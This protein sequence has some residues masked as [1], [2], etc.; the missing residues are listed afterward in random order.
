MAVTYREGAS[1][2]HPYALVHD[3][4]GYGK[5]LVAVDRYQTSKPVARL[6]LPQPT[7]TRLPALRSPIFRARDPNFEHLLPDARH[8]PFHLLVQCPKETVE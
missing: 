4:S 3:E 7:T 5:R 1:I 8:E 6:V 2:D